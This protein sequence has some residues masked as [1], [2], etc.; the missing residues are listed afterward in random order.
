MHLVAP[1]GGFSRKNCVVGGAWEKSVLSTPF[2]RDM[3]SGK[4]MA[5]ERAWDK[6]SAFSLPNLVFPDFI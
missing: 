3:R 1:E 2:Q 6:I 5:R 4:L